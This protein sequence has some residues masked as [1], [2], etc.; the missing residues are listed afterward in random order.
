MQHFLQISDLSSDDIE[1]LTERA[2]HF[3]YQGHYP[4][5]TSSSV[6]NLFYENS[7]RTRISF[8]LAAKHLS[9]E[10]INV[11]LQHSS[12]NK[13]ETIQ[14]T[15]QTLGAM[16]ITHAVIR[17]SQD[18]LPA[19]LTTLCPHMHVVNAGDG[20]HAHPSQAMLDFMTIV[21]Q[22]PDMH[23]L[24]IAIIGDILH[25]RVANSLQCLFKI[26]QPK[27]LILVAPP[28]WQP[29]VIH[30]GQITDNLQ[31]G[32][33][34]ADVVICLRVQRERL[35][36]EEFMDLETYRHHFALTPETFAWC[37]PDAMIMHPG[38]VNREVEIDS[39]LVDGAH[40]AI[41]QQVKNGVFMRMAILEA[42]GR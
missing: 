42:L 8:E 24:K 38:P 33:A 17:H 3:K 21:E 39:I 16:G 30:Y 29:E 32:L 35:K 36:K 7:T 15:L 26:M 10:V 1:T 13:G 20:T 23:L 25:S 6:V 9:M 4:H 18:H 12:E 11:D 40:S 34:D 14:D 28:I 37:K 41:L 19:Q 5:Y 27:E 2:L 22:K 31:A